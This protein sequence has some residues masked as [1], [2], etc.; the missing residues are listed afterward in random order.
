MLLWA[1]TSDPL[2]HPGRHNVNL[3]LLTITVFQA[4]NIRN[5]RMKTPPFMNGLFDI[6]DMI[7]GAGIW[8]AGIGVLIAAI[9]LIFMRYTG[10]AGRVVSGLIGA[11]G[12]AILI[13]NAG[14]FLGVFTTSTGTAA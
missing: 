12:G 10:G 3:T 1:G 14:A 6:Y 5:P 8:L 7:A 4:F 13:I 9:G 11:V 2:N